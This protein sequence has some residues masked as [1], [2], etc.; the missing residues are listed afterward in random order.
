MTDNIN[1]TQTNINQYHREAFNALRSS[2]YNNFTLF[3]CFVDGEPA[4]A[5]VAV[6]PDGDDYL[7]TPLFV[8]IT[9]TMKLTD[10]EGC[11]PL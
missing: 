1:T 2:E 5:I 11:A 8:S 7:I 10:H 4:A 9:P 3:S 6:K